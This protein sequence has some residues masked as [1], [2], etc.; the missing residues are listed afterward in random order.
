MNRN[1][2]NVEEG[3]DCCGYLLIILSYIAFLITLPI[4]IFMSFKVKLVI[5]FLI[6]L[7]KDVY[8]CQIVKEY[9]RAVILRLGR[10]LPGGAKGKKITL[11]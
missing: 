9:E 11:H 8:I 7:I 4:S 6:K 3:F 2:E 1:N 5:L 10:I